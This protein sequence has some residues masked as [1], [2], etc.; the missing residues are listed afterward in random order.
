MR[1]NQIQFQLTIINRIE[2]EE[3]AQEKNCRGNYQKAAK[4]LENCN[5]IVVLVEVK[6]WSGGKT[7]H[8]WN[9]RLDGFSI[10]VVIQ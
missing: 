6:L 2:E 5:K 8:F 3:E 1:F 10:V 9:Y 7:R 4:H